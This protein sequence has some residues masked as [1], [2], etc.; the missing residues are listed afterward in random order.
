MYKKLS[1]SPPDPPLGALAPD[2]AGGPGT[3]WGLRPQ[4]PV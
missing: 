1:A 3:R 4:T 2:P